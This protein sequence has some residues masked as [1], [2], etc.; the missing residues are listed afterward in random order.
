MRGKIPAVQVYQFPRDEDTQRI[1]KW[2]GEDYISYLIRY[3][4]QE[5]AC[6]ES[7]TRL[8]A[9]SCED[10]PQYDTFIRQGDGVITRMDVHFRVGVVMIDAYGQAQHASV[11]LTITGKSLD[12]PNAA[13]ILPY[14]RIQ[15]AEPVYAGVHV[16]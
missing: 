1:L 14:A 3:L 2:M 4:H 8:E 11:D 5:L 7:G 13:R 12:K 10:G 9:I 16:F 15:R 6:L